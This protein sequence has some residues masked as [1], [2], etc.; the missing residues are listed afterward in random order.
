MKTIGIIGYGF[1]GEGLHHYVEEHV[2]DLDVVFIHGRSPERLSGVEKKLRLESLDDFPI[3]GMRLPDL[4]VEAAH[5]DVTRHYGEKILR[6]TNYMPLSTA[7]LIEEDARNR[8]KAVAAACRTEL[9]LPHGAVVGLDSLIEWKDQW[10]EV[11][12]TFRKPPE[13]IDLTQMV[14]CPDEIDRETTLAHGSVRE[15]ASR[16]PRNV[17]AMVTCALATIGLDRCIGKLVAVPGLDT[18]SLRIEAQGRDGTLLTI[19][20]TQPA[21]G[22][23]GTEMLASLCRSVGRAL[24]RRT[25]LEFI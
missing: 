10:R 17:N 22:V 23:S 8:L 20:R 9:L 13:S 15:L 19:E 4:V 14:L 18:L 12:I 3:A 21:A 11:T 16:F 25:A 1:L 6:V 5:P 2:T 24:N 7:A